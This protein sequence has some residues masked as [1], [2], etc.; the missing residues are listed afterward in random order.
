MVRSAGSPGYGGKASS[1]DFGASAGAA[2][3]SGFMGAGGAFGSL[4]GEAGRGWL[5]QARAAAATTNQ[6][7]IASLYELAGAWR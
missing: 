4:S 5:L 1:L 2:G 6:S 7:L 3:G